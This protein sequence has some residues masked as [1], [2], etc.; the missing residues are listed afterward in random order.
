MVFKA[1]FQMRE[2]QGFLQKTDGG[3]FIAGGSTKAQRTLAG[4][5]GKHSGNID[6][7]KKQGR[8]LIARASPAVSRGRQHY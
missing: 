2:D 1:L 7:I 5:F 6:E 8:K 3:L 4:V